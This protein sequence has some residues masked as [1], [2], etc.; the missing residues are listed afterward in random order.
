MISEV[1]SMK[2]GFLIWLT[3]G[4]LVGSVFGQERSDNSLIIAAKVNR[5]HQTGFDEGTENFFDIVGYKVLKVCQGDY[6]VSDINVAH[7]VGSVKDLKVGD[8][9]CRRLRSTVKLR[10]VAKLLFEGTGLSVSED[11][12]ADYVFDTSDDT[13]ECS[14]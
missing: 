14:E 7:V 13:C 1:I 2:K 5:I 10:D 8:V 12:L 11:Y 4:L 9:V 3:M 6:V